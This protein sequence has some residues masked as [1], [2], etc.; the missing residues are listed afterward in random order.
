MRFLQ[1]QIL[2]R[3]FLDLYRTIVLKIYFQAVCG[4]SILL[5]QK[6]HS[7]EI[8]FLLVCTRSITKQTGTH[9]KGGRIHNV[10]KP[11]DRHHR[12]GCTHNVAQVTYYTVRW[13]SLKICATCYYTKGYLCKS[14][15]FVV[16]FVLPSWSSFPQHFY[17]K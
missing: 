10:P 4:L 3:L 1:K 17:L 9:S 16:Y 11:T 15:F 2:G 13:R 14:N 5:S 8:G 7:L 6:L 12:G